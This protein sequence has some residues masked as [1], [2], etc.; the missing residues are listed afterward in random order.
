MHRP[1]PGLVAPVELGVGSVRVLEVEEHHGDDASVAIDLV[2]DQ[3]S[4][5]ASGPPPYAT[6]PVKQCRLSERRWPRVA[7]SGS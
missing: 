7:R 6:S 2:E 5:I 4:S 3:W 1:F